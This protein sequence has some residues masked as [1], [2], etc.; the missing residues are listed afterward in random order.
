M[1]WATR[2]HTRMVE[3]RLLAAGGRDVAAGVVHR[4]VDCAELGL[5]R[6][7]HARDL[8]AVG[9]VAQRPAD[10]H[11]VR[12]GDRAR[13]VGERRAFAVLG[14]PVLAHAMDPDRA[15]E[16]GETLGERAPEPAP[17]PGDQRN[18]P[19]QRACTLG[20]V[21]PSLCSAPKSWHVRQRTGKPAEIAPLVL[22]AAGGDANCCGGPRGGPRNGCR[23]RRTAIGIS[24]PA[25]A[26]S[27]AAAGAARPDQGEPPRRPDLIPT[28]VR[29]FRSTESGSVRTAPGR[30]G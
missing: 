19:C 9:Q 25:G 12:F 13:G 3:S 7:D 10:R 23:K 28:D 4:D 22:L 2:W 18:L 14:R 17:R 27:G 16:R 1:P 21:I 24:I 5:D 15:P 11:A 6:R 8:S 26:A 30:S 20:H 29:A